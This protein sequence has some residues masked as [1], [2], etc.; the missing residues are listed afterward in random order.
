MQ[1]VGIG[2]LCLLSCGLG[3]AWARQDAEDGD[4]PIRAE[5]GRTGP[6]W[7][8]F[9]LAALRGEHARRGRA[10]LDFLGVDTLS[11]GLY[12]LPA[13]AT[14]EQSPHDQ[15]E[16]YV[17]ERGRAT[18]VVGEDRLAVEPGSVAFVAAHVPHRFVAIEEDLEVLVFFS[19][20]AVEADE[21]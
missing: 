12:R 1:L 10:Y 20:A 13:G 16:V 21:E 5:S 8:S 17:V 2:L 3:V 15:D 9:E 6:G 14:D 7:A 4:R 18:L 11:M 19:K